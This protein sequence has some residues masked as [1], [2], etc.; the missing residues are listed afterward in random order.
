VRTGLAAAAVSL[1]VLGLAVH[2]LRGPLIALFSP[3]PETAVAATHFVGVISF[4]YAFV[5]MGIVASGAFQGLGRGLPFLLLT[6]LRLV[7]VSAPAAWF[8]STRFG[9]NAFHFAP[10][11][12]SAFS[13]TVA[14]VW[15]LAATRRLRARDATPEP[16]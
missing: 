10:L 13:G 16:S 15:I 3:E 4:G 5:G 9:E 8:L 7:L 6:V 14:V 2:F 11:L 1:C 12:S